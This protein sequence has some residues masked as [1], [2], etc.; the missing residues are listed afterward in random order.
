L[1]GL[2]GQDLPEQGVLLGLSLLLGLLNLTLLL[3]LS[4]DLQHSLL[5]DPFQFLVRRH[6]VLLNIS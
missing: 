4:L 1:A 3:L 6:R 5:P 2:G